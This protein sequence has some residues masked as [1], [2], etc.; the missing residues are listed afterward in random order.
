MKHRVSEPGAGAPTPAAKA[1]VLPSTRALT[2]L[3]A[4]SLCKAPGFWALPPISAR[5][6]PPPRGDSA[7][8][9]TW[10]SA[11]DR[12]VPFRDREE[13]LMAPLQTPPTAFRAR[14]RAGE[15]QGT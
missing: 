1:P 8:L 7:P 15:R 12:G 10:P 11:P 5:R 4:T 3:G 9:Y 6:P 14:A 13:P 2:W